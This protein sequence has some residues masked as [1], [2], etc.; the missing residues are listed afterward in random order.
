MDSRLKSVNQF[1]LDGDLI[2]LYKSA[3]EASRITGIA[4]TCITRCCRRER[5]QTNGFFFGNISKIKGGLRKPP[6][7][8]NKILKQIYKEL[9]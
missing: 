5:E 3:S 2:A 1:S 7:L 6:F 9:F 4:K 8:L